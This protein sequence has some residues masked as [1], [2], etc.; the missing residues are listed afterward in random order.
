ML[1]FL[2]GFGRVVFPLAAAFPFLEEGFPY[3]EVR[4]V[5]EYDYLH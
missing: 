2:S 1:L 3:E 4:G 5:G